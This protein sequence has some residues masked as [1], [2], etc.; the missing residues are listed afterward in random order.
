MAFINYDDYWKVRDEIK[1][2]LTGAPF[3]ETDP[4]PPKLKK[5]E[6]TAISLIR[7]YIGGRFDCDALFSATGDDRNMFILDIVVSITLYKLCQ[8]TG[9]KDIPEHR[10]IE[11]DDAI[12]WLTQAGKAEIPVTDLPPI[13]GEEADVSGDFQI[14]SREPN[15]WKT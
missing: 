1:K 5:A 12:A 8:Q 7:M 6:D 11:Y 4:K 2:V 15:D 9:M 14:S 3:T 13:V 10:K